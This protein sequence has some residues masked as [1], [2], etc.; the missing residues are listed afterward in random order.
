MALQLHNLSIGEVSVNGKGAKSAPF[1]YG[2]D[3]VIWIPGSQMQV[4]YEPGVY[5]GEDVSRVN[6]VLRPPEDVRLQL[7]ALDDFVVSYITENSER[8][9]GKHLT[10]DQ[11]A[12]RYQPV[13]RHSDKQYPPSLR[14]KM[15]R[16][17]KYACKFWQHK[18][19]RHAPETWS[20]SSVTVR[21]HVKSLY[22]MGQN[23]GVTIDVTDVSIESEPTSYCPF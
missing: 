2:K 22:L 6:L 10:Q 5:S 18:E 23:F 15:N 3:P 1:L 4:A 17:G 19:P 11:V 7:Q 16:D 21:L 8:V 12:A 9:L 13:L 14:V 20:G